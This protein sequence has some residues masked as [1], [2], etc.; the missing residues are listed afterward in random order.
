MGMAYGSSILD[1]TKLMCGQK[2]RYVLYCPSLKLI[3]T[4]LAILLALLL[5]A[6]E[7]KMNRKCEKAILVPEWHLSIRKEDKILQTIEV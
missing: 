3:E 5:L 2:E 6:L 4:I 1:C 7:R